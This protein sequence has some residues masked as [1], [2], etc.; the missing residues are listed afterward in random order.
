[1]NNLMFLC[2][3]CNK[4]G[5]YHIQMVEDDY[6]LCQYHMEDA[7]KQTQLCNLFR[8]QL[9]HPIKIEVIQ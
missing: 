9:E 2:A 3:D 4:D 7:W 8:F 5:I 1:M 6:W